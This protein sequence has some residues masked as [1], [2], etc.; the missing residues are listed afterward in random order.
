[1]FKNLT[2]RMQL[3]LLIGFLSLLLAALGAAGLL[4]ISQSN[5]RLRSAYEH[6]TVPMSQLAEIRYL[7]ASNRL[8]VESTL[9]TSTEEYTKQQADRVEKNIAEISRLW[10]E[11]LAGD[12]TPEEKDLAQQLAQLRGKFV[13]QGLKPAL[14]ALRANDLGTAGTVAVEAMRPLAEPVSSGLDALVKLQLY[15]GKV[16]YETATERYQ[17]AL[18]IGI[19]SVAAGVL[20]AV[21]VG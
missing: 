13:A 8:A 11:Y 2:I 6:R 4:G 12:L 21:L 14:A 17:L 5:D 20:I 16:E 10:D 15:R 19:G 1:M 3:V 9:I 7:I 18:M